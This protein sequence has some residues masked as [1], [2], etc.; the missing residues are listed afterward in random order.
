MIIADLHKLGKS[1]V[2]RMRRMAEAADGDLTDFHERQLVHSLFM[3]LE[4]AH[5]RSLWA[6]FEY[7]YYK[8]GHGWLRGGGRA[9]LYA[10]VKPVHA[11]LEVKSTGLNPDGW[12]N[13][14]L[15]IWLNDAR[16]LLQVKDGRDTQIGWVWLFLFETYR[17]EIL[18]L[19]TGDRWTAPRRP[20]DAAEFFGRIDTGNGRLARS[21]YKLD[22][23]ASDPL[24]GA[25]ARV[26]F[27]PQLPR[28]RYNVWNPKA[29]EYSA[30]LLTMDLSQGFRADS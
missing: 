21:L 16:K 27:L 28:A 24:H 30:M 1:A 13:S 8:D 15:D 25:A 20:K 5:G 14:H 3:E 23:Y 12:D 26:S 17:S 2:D 19:G 10:W 11:W 18:A 7:R 6:A 22:V 29:T 4:K 9:D